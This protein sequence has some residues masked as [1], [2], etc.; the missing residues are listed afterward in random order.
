MSDVVSVS[1]SVSEGGS[2]GAYDEETYEV[3]HI[4]DSR[5][6]SGKTQYYIKWKNYPRYSNTVSFSG[7]NE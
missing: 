5:L 2:K 3:E 1:S 7:R 4:I 6:L